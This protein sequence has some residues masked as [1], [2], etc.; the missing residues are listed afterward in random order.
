M[1]RLESLPQVAE[2][3]ATSVAFWRKQVYLRRIPVVKVGRLTRPRL[4]RPRG[5]GAPGVGGAYRP[6]RPCSPEKRVGNR[7]DFRMVQP[8]TAY[9][10]ATC[11]RHHIG[12]I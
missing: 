3:T 8:R 12:R 4:V 11:V 5:G 10:T 6:R 9:T 1:E 2:R 7:G